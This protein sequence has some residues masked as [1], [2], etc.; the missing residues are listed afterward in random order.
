MGA[1]ERERD[2]AG[3]GRYRTAGRSRSGASGPR[4]LEGYSRVL[5]PH[6]QPLAQRCLG[7]EAVA[8]EQGIVARLRHRL[9]KSLTGYR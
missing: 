6:R 5:T 9:A 8:E 3:S 7:H 1:A 2:Y 4:V